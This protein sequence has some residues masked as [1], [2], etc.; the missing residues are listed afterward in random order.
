MIGKKQVKEGWVYFGLQFIRILKLLM[1]GKTWCMSRLLLG[2]IGFH[3]AERR[4]NG[5]ELPIFK[6]CPS[7][8]LPLA[9]FNFLGSTKFSMSVLVQKLRV[10]I[11]TFDS[12]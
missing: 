5:A 11:K 1:A 3:E 12:H 9:R 6:A 8:P 7:V 2:F 10:A 4:G